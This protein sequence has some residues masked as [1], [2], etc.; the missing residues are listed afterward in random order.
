MSRAR[1]KLLVLTS[2]FPRW[3]GDATPT[4]VAD[5][6]AGLAQTMDVTVLAPASDGAP[7]AERLGNVRVRRFRYAWPARLQLLAD[8]AIMPNIRRNPL[9]AA[10][11]PPFVLAELLAAWRL[12]RS[13]RFDVIHAHWAVP[14]GLVA[15]TLK[16][17]FGVPVIT[18]THGGDI[19]ALRSGPAMR[20]KQWALASSDRITA[21]STSLKREIVALGLDERSVDVLPMGVDTSRFT[22]EARSESLRRRLN[23][24]GPV[25]LF[26]GRLVEKKGA[27][28]AIEAMPRILAQQPLARLVIVGDGPERAHLQR[29]ARAHGISRTRP[30]RRPRSQRG[31]ASVLRLS[32]RLR[33]T[34]GRRARRRHRVLRRGVRRGDGQRLPRRGH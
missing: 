29:L 1:L 18:T 30:L 33:G 9:L 13:E 27:R 23:P 20:A 17:A 14:Q 11:V 21:V 5:L 32:G 10:E 34:V 6:C 16:R 4:F 3:P 31:A 12:M 15:A 25:L 19:Y 26:V 8:G 2:T 22:P 28:Y 7:S 24:D